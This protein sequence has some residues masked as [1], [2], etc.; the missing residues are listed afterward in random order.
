MLKIRVNKIDELFDIS[1]KL[2]TV[3]YLL[4]LVTEHD[5]ITEYDKLLGFGKAHAIDFYCKIS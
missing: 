4:G 1:L 2:G 5:E 3:T